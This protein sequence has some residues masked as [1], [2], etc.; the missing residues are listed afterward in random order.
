MIVDY[1][2]YTFKPG[3]IPAFYEMFE[4][5]GL[6]PQQRI[7]GNFIGMYR[8]EVGNVNEVIHMWGYENALERDQR[9]AELYKD[10]V[11]ADY[12]VRARELITA[13]DVRTLIP[14]P[15]NPKQAAVT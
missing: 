10:P 9:R 3:T 13:Q 14:A 1:R 11:F 6:E 12:V 5:E 2:A 15:F 4:K 8:T 7:L